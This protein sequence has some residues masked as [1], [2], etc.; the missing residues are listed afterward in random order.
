MRQKKNSSLRRSSQQSAVETNKK[1]KS[2]WN[3][4]IINIRHTYLKVS[5]RFQHTRQNARWEENS[6]KRTKKNVHRNTVQV[7]ISNS[8][9][10]TEYHKPSHHTTNESVMHWAFDC[11]WI[12]IY[13]YNL[14]A[15][16]FIHLKLKWHLCRYT[17]TSWLVFLAL[18]SSQAVNFS[19]YL[20]DLTSSVD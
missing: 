16:R 12:R 14:L 1:N 10:H 11:D 13:F 6:K 3:I 5:S 7:G 19:Q 15:P 17:K 20:F 9:P 8:V 18:F 4:I 2:N